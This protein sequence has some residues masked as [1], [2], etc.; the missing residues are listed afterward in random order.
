MAQDS[1]VKL[2]QLTMYIFTAPSA[3][4]SFVLIVIL[5]LLVDGASARA[6]LHLPFTSNIGFTLPAVLSS[7]ISL[8]R[9]PRV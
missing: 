3:L 4:R 1:D 5:G 9:H 7:K 2:G 6:W 8:F